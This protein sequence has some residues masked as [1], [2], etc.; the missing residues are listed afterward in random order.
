M[1][2]FSKIFAV[3]LNACIVLYVCFFSYKLFSLLNPQVF[4]DE[5]GGGTI[6]TPA[7]PKGA[8]IKVDAGDCRSRLPAIPNLCVSPVSGLE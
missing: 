6:F 1:I 3:C 7:W 5:S 4:I 8:V 2:R